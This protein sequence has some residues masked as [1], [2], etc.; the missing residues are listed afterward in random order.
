M[1]D[2]PEPASK[3]FKM[4]ADYA[5]EYSGADEPVTYGTRLHHDM[6]LVGLDASY[7]LD[8]YAKKF[9]VVLKDFMFDDYFRDEPEPFSRLIDLIIRNTQ[10]KK[11]LTLGHLMKGIMAGRLDETIIN[12]PEP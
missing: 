7:F 9:H 4:L 2:S 6:G 1:N 3:L 12:G 5:V 8:W 11:T 10:P